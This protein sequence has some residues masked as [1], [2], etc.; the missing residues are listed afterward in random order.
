MTDKLIEQI[1]ADREAGTPGPWEF[2]DPNLYDDP[3]PNEIVG[4]LKGAT[5]YGEKGVW[6]VC[7][8]DQD[9]IEDGHPRV[10]ADARRIARV[11]DMESR[12]LAGAEVIEALKAAL[13]DIAEGEPEWPDDPAREWQWCRK[14]AK[15]ALAPFNAALEAREKG[16]E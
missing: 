5:R 4:Q 7:Q 16:G 12:I 3:N 10:V 2:R 1:K 9:D 14:R 6:E 11:H 8:L 15:E 13:A